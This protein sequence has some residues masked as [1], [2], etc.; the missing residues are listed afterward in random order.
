MITFI[1]RLRKGLLASGTSR[2]YAIYAIGEIAL[3]VIGILIAL[4]VNN[5][6]EGQKER[7]IEVK[8][9]KEVAENLGAN[10]L[11][12]QSMIDRCNE[13]NQSADVIISVIDNNFFY[14]DSLNR[15]FYF[16]L[17]PVDEGSFLSY[18]GFES[19]KNIGFEIIRD[20][21]LKKE[22]INL[23]EGIYRDLQAK[24]NRVNLVAT[25]NLSK[26]RDQHFLFQL[27]SVRQQ[28]GHMPV[29]FDNLIKNKH[30]KSWLLSTR[31]VR[32]WIESSLHESLEETQR[33]LQLINEE[34]PST[35]NR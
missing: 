10:I 8:V 13:D 31:G 23:F 5:W 17:N 26:F 24:Y 32:L 15:Y 28:I 2:K 35:D 1:R 22:I 34:L 7:G 12:L 9:L 3:V 6:N 14:S 25:P 33:V 16:A 29:D 20:D 4:Q 11:R 19:L 30:F 21:Q 18:V 27:D